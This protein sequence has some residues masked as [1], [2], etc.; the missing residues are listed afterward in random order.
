MRWVRAPVI[1]IP[2]DGANN[3]GRLVTAAWDE[4]VAQG[5][6]I[7]GLPLMLKRP[8]GLRDI[9]DLALY[10]R[11]SVIGGPGAFMIPAGEAPVRRSHPD[12][13]PPCDCGTAAST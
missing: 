5:V 4:A 13:G 1:D 6:T 8:D 10:F 3:H 12:E 2:G 9:E 7:N 11:V